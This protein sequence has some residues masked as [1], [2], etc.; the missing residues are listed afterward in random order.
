MVA[1]R[2]TSLVGFA[3]LH[4]SKVAT[5]FQNVLPAM[6]GRGRDMSAHLPCI[7]SYSKWNAG[8]GTAGLSFAITHELTKV[9]TQVIQNIRNSVPHHSSPA[10]ALAG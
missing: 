10:R 9:H 6:L 7:P 3:T 8:N 5:S 2:H 1:F 4:E